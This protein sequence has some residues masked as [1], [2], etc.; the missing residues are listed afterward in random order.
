M[1]KVFVTVG[2]VDGFD[3]GTEWTYR[4]VQRQFGPNRFK[5]MVEA[6]E[7]LSFE[8]GELEAWR[9][10][11]AMAANLPSG[12]GSAAQGALDELLA[13]AEAEGGAFDASE[14]VLKRKRAPRSAATIEVGGFGLVTP[15]QAEA[16]RAVRK[17]AV[18]AD[19]P[20]TAEVA[21]VMGLPGQAVMVS[22]ILSSLKERGILDSRFVGGKACYSEVK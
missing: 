11:K 6:G 13:V 9:A 22:G 4:E 17:Y 14:A 21:Q 19:D 7:M 12:A 5:A 1:A 8:E 2:S 18:H 3:A 15:L 10:E 20:T 16:L